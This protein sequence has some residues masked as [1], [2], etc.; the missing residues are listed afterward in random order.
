MDFGPAKT[1]T[2]KLHTSKN[3]TRH[4]STQGRSALHREDL[5]GVA[6]TR[7][8]MRVDA[9]LFH[10]HAAGTASTGTRPSVGAL[11]AATGALRTRLWLLRVRTEPHH[12]SGNC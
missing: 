8:R 3:G 12:L 9:L 11:G 1:R 5:R 6:Y 7:A 2:D 4:P 10:T